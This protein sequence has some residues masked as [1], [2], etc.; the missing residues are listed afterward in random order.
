MNP[1]SHAAV[2]EGCRCDQY[3]NQF[4]AG[5][6]RTTSGVPAYHIHERCPLHGPGTGWT[7][8]ESK[9]ADLAPLPVRGWYDPKPKKKGSQ[10]GGGRKP[11]PVGTC[12]ECLNERKLHT[13]L[14]KCHECVRSA[15]Y[16]E[17]KRAKAGGAR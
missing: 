2:Q 4:G 14:G 5:M 17:R 10:N 3:E 15:R 8:Q 7:W 13:K 11:A 9:A 16:F 12:P 6:G 1:G